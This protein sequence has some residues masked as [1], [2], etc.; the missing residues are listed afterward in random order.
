MTR[1]STKLGLALASVVLGAGALCAA[2]AQAAELAIDPN[3]TYLRTND[4]PFAEQAA[5]IDLQA[6]GILPGDQIR[7]T[8]RGDF[9]FSLAPMDQAQGL[10]GLFST[11]AVISGNTALLNRV[12]GAVAAPGTLPVVTDPTFIGNVPTDI[13]Q[14]FLI[15]PSPAGAS[16]SVTVVVPAGA[17]YLFLTPIDRGFGDNSDPD[18]NFTL[19]IEQMDSDHDGVPDNKDMFLN[20]DLRAKVDTGSGPTSINNVVD[21]T[22]GSIQDYVNLLAA[23]ARNHGQYVVAIKALADRLVAMGVITPA[24]AR[25]MHLGAA[26]SDIGKK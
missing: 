6:L 15:S 17:R 11:T 14:D 24:Q 12:P 7:L 1:F 4:D 5:P 2:P 25:E 13:P 9:Q 22:G 8:R 18:N 21:A 20:S 16:V 19:V 23:N 3:A 26:R 10:A